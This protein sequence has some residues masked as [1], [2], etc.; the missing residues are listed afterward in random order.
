MQKTHPSTLM[1][2]ILVAALGYLFW[3]ARTPASG[4][5]V[6]SPQ[7]SVSHGKIQQ[8]SFEL[9]S[10]AEHQE[11]LQ[12]KTAF[13]MYYAPWCQ[14]CEEV[15]P[16]FKNVQRQ[17]STQGIATSAVNCVEFP[18]LCTQDDVPIFPTIKLAQSGQTL[19][20]NGKREQV[21]MLDFVFEHL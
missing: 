5:T 8:Q 7:T 2:S 18:D 12:A 16:T 3:T 21:P 11:L 19:T 10:M 20:Y 17:L 6:L 4:N 14:V 9:S 1:L 15:L 13:I